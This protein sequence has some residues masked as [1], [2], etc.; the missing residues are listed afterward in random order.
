[1]QH[2]YIAFLSIYPILVL[3]EAGLISQRVHRSAKQGQIPEN[4]YK[5]IE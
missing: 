5:L 3:A 1:V 4:K 2:T